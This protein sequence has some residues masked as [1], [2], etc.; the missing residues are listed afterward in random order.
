MLFDRIIIFRDS[1]K[2]TGE[3]DTTKRG[4]T[5]RLSWSGSARTVLF[6]GPIRLVLLPITSS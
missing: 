3:E 4:V 2:T 1:P 5:Y 6:E